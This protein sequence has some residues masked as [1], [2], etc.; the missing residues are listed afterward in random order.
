MKRNQ[1][2]LLSLVTVVGL[3]LQ[4]FSGLVTSQ[5]AKAA[6]TTPKQVVLV[7]SLQAVLGNSGDWDPSSVKTQMD[8]Q[9][10]GLYSLTGTLPSGTYEYKI[11]IGGGWS[12][13]YGDGGAPG[14]NNIKLTL[15]EQKKV[16][17]YY[18]DNTHAIADSTRYTLLNEDKKPRLVGTIQPAIHAGT[19]WSPADSTALM[20]DTHFDNVYS[21]T[22]KVPRG[23]YEYKIVLGKDW[24]ESYPG[25]NEKL[26]VLSDTT[27]TFFYNN[28][29]KEV[30]SD[31]KPIGSDGMI[32]KDALYHDSW[33]QV[34]RTPFGAVPAG[35]PVTFRVSAKK[36]DLTRASL[37]VKNYNTGTTKVLSMKNTGWS[38]TKDKGAIEF[39]EATFTP[40]DKGVH[41]YKFIAGD[42]DT[43][44][45]YG[46]DTQEGHTGKAEDKNAGLFQ[47]TVFDPGYQTPDWMKEAVVYQ[48]YPD[49]FYNGNKANDHVKDQIGA[50]GSQ[51]I[52][53]PDSW[54]SLPDNPYEQGTGSYTGDGEFTNDFFGGDIAGIKAKLDY[55][56][57]LGVNTLYLNP[58]ALAPSNHK[59]DATDYKQ[60]DPMFGSEKEFEDFAK[61]LSK[62]NMHLILDGVFNHVADD[63][64]YFDRYHKYKTVG[65]YEYWS[66]I[67]DLMNNEKLSETAAKDKAKQQLLAEGQTFSP[68]GFENWFHIENVKVPNEKVNGVSTGEHYK[69]EGWWGY[70]S[71]PVFESVN[72]TK[73]DHPS[74]LNNTALA[75]Y[76]FYDKDSV[77]KT[78]IDRGSSGWRL[79]VAN[80]VDSSFW[81]EFRKQMKSKTMI[82][83]GKTLQKEEEPLI[84]GEI[85]D[86]ASKYFLGDQYDSVMNYRFRGAILDYLK[87]GNAANAQNTLLAIQEDYPKEAFYALM[88]LMGSHDTARAVFLL[89]NGTDTYNRAEQD[90]YYNFN[91]GVKRLKLASILQMGYPGAPTI[92]YGDE[93]GQTG[94]KDPDDRRTYPWG[95]ENKDLIA[96]YQKI[97]QIRKENADLFAHGD[98]HHLYAKGDVLAYVRTKETKS[99][100]VIINR[101]KTTQTVDIDTKVL[102]ANGLRF[103]DQLDPKYLTT[104]K[105][106]KLSLTVP[107]ESG[108]MLITVND[109]KQPQP[110]KEVTGTAGSKEV[111]LSWTGTGTGTKYNVYQSTVSGGLWTK[112]KETT[113][114]SVNISDLN[115]GRTYYFTVTALNESGNESVPAA[116]SGLVPH[117]DAAKA[118]I[119]DLTTLDNG[120]LNLAQSSN[121]KAAFYLPGASETGAAEGI[122]AD[123]QVRMKGQTAWTSYQALYNGQTQGDQANEFQGSF[124]AYEAG[125]YEYRMAFTPDLGNTW[126]YSITGEVTFSHS[127][128]DTTPPANDV[129]LDTPIKESGQVNLNWKLTQ[130]DQPFKTVIY[131]DGQILSTL[132]GSAATFRDYQVA[133]GT[134]YQYQVRVYDQAGNHVE[135]NKVS[136]TP[137]I[138]MVQVTLKVHAPDY[139][140]LAAQVNI[141]GS[142]NGWNTSAWTMSRNGAVT[143]DWEYTVELEEG[144]ELT[145]K[146]T[147]DNTWDHEGLADH[148]PSDHSDDDISNYGYGAAGTDMK[149]V[150]TNQGNNKM[151]VQDT[152]L[153][154]I[155]MPLAVSQIDV[156][157]STMTIKGN[158]IKGADL[159]I[160]GEKVTVGNDMNFTQSFTVQAGQTQVPVHIAPNDTTK[161]TIF[162]GDGGSI[163]KNTKNYVIDVITKTISETK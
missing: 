119:K 120:E 22:A 55:L 27:I 58:I 49:R 6:E 149:I 67:Y 78:W 15:T 70:D 52:E 61:E 134:A 96:H 51:P 117:Y 126:V 129:T 65:A 31:Y 50:R 30:Y 53:H 16:T 80:E 39:W 111:T 77:G 12:E 41:G 97:G 5:T 20:E 44:V 24:T 139:T 87:N 153:R 106:G 152:I 28:Q 121:V 25:S 113:G 115:N 156:N 137:E 86:D 21:F 38:D 10:N 112:V 125:T 142:L 48:I 19:A 36:G 47:L 60:V 62:R 107:A 9:G 76:I 3:I 64:I 92:Y 146:Y 154:W 54:S 150:V 94:S 68:Y 33:D 124:T 85:W 42:Q 63:S 26:N 116:S 23:S 157:G 40:S 83:A 90:P 131:R 32:D 88:N 82:G 130:P 46:E 123:L 29:T 79:D 135:S 161:S 1:R 159:T 163:N 71:L 11:A 143:P 43:T 140:P 98:L 59:Y 37:Y 81:Q 100:L 148:T 145:Y 13:N 14:G 110:V 136:V 17:F 8:Y 18:N 118:S 95:N 128:S 7:G 69:Y 75:N 73:V 72:G 105:D 45:E 160:N 155:D 133:N 84:L 101:G 109:V 138:V 4:L 162:K 91:E 132:D 103:V 144:T 57:S 2:T 147:R 34:Y 102:L 74:E 56:Q 104:T 93:A 99:G 114:T 158:A 89:G 35:K 108:R 66:R 122:T 127:T 141:P 151:V